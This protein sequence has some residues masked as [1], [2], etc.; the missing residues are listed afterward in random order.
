M[1]RKGRPVALP[2]RYVAC[3]IVYA[4]GMLHVAS[5]MPHGMLQVGC[6]TDLEA[7]K[8]E[9]P[10]ELLEV[11][12]LDNVVQPRECGKHTARRAADAD[13]DER[14]SDWRLEVEGR[15]QRARPLAHRPTGPASCDI[16]HGASEPAVG[17]DRSGPGPIRS[18]PSGGFKDGTQCI[19]WCTAMVR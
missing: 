12:A 2:V 10:V 7:H 19:G 15:D 9:R 18:A 16:R 14:R 17:S 6:H 8:E 3:R 4:H 5:C 11:T 1:A 13:A